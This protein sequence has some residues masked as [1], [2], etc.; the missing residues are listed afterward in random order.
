MEKC[1]PEGVAHGSYPVCVRLKLCLQ[2]R[3]KGVA[4]RPSPAFPA[5]A[6]GLSLV[7]GMNTTGDSVR[8]GSSL[9]YLSHW[10]LKGLRNSMRVF[11]EGGH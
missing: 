5:L 4:S 7:L 10:A 8:E 3:K 2:S 6:E 11:E 9:M 1:I